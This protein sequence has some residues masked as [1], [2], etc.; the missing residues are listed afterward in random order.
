MKKIRNQGIN[1]RTYHEFKFI[2]TIHP[3]QFQIFILGLI[4]IE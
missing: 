2:L 3:I 1:H 4:I